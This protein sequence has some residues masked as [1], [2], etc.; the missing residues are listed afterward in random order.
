[1]AET[2]VDF[3]SPV[4]ITIDDS[5][6]S[7][8][9]GGE[10]VIDMTA[11]ADGAL[12]A[13]NNLSD[14]DSASS[15]RT[16]LGSG[17]VGDSLFVANDAATARGLLGVTNGI[18]QQVTIRNIV[19]ATAEVYRFVAGVGGEITAGYLVASNTIAAGDLVV[20]LAIEGA[21]VGGGVMTLAATSTA[22]TIATCTPLGAT[23]SQGDLISA[24][25]SGGNTAAGY[26]DV[27]IV[28]TVP[29]V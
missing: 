25:V 11:G 4:Q 3:I 5:Q 26:G 20:T 23:V 14:L 9:P 28:I 13:A 17:T 22:G 6:V 7:V 29:E 16:N 12:L 8:G 21:P 15:A 18:P 24:T 1:M 27:T 19:S 2:T 10:T